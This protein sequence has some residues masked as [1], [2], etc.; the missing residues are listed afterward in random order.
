MEAGLD[1]EPQTGPGAWRAVGVDEVAAGFAAIQRGLSNARV[2]AISAQV[3]L[4]TGRAFG[5]HSP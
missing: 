4:I 2:E 1:T 5:F 3:R